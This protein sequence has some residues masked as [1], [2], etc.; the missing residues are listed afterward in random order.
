M[1][2]TV[3]E[4]EKRLP[5]IC[6]NITVLNDPKIFDTL[7]SLRTQAI[8]PDLVL[9]ADG[10][11]PA[12]YI[13]RIK[14][15][16]T[17]LPMKVTILPGSPI[18][19][20][21]A[22]LDHITTDI[23]A[24]LDSDEIA[25]PDWLEKITK[26]IVSE[27]AD[28]TG[29]P[30]RP[31]TDP[32]SSIEKYYNELETRIYEG[33]VEQDVVYMPL[34]NTAWR[35]TLLK[36]LRF[37]SR[38]VFRGGAPDYDLEMRAVDAGYRGMFISEAWVYHNKS[39]TKGY[40]ALLKHRYRYLVGAAVVMIKNKRLGKRFTEK[41]TRVRMPFAYVEMAMKPIALVHAAIYWEF[42]VKRKQSRI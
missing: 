21:N 9:V 6:V 16:F 19:T 24:F 4:N 5:T 18:T 8:R 40:G 31:Y 10:G 12:G 37:D 22:S 23:T 32:A 20:K 25:P 1:T 15:E 42:V 29:G 3:E 14:A 36:Q 35:T 26:P 38:I 39:T 34:G 13:E 30:T 33:D 11:S 2:E 27:R 7:N 17:D 28:F 41:R